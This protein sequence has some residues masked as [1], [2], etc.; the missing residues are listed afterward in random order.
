MEQSKS[1][2]QRIL[3][4][5]RAALLGGTPI[6]YIKTDSDV[7]VRRIVETSDPPLV[8]P[9][10]GGEAGVKYAHRPVSE[11]KADGLRCFDIAMNVKYNAPDGYLSMT[12]PTIWI[13][14]M[15]EE[16]RADGILQ[17]LEK[18]VA[19]HENPEHSVYEYLQSSVVIVYS[20]DVVI[21]PTLRP[22]T[23]FIDV[24]FP[25]EGEIRKIVLEESGNSATLLRNEEQMNKLCTTFHG[26]STE[27]IVSTMRRVMAL[28]S[29]EDPDKVEEL[30]LQRKMQRM[31]G[32]ALELVSAN[33]DIGGMEGFR[34]WL[35]KQVAALKNAGTY[36]RE[37]GTMPPKGVLLCGIPGCGKSEAAKFTAKTL[38]LPLLKMDVGNLMDMY[39]G[40]SEQKM[41]EALALAEAMSPCV[42]WI[43]ELEKGFSQSSGGSSDSGAAF[44]R[45]FGYMLGW[46]Q[47]NQEPCFIFATANNIGGLPK[48]FFRSGRF[49]ALYAVY[50]PTAEECVGI[51]KTSME[52]AR[53]TKASALYPG[54]KDKPLRQKVQIFAPDCFDDKI[55]LDAVNDHLV[56]D[57]KPR[58]VI[59]S[60]IQKIVSTAL[61]TLPGEK[62]ISKQQWIKALTATL[63]NQKDCA[64]YG[65]GQENI[66]S[67][68]V[69][70]CRMLRKNFVPTADYVLFRAE[71]YNAANLSEYNRLRATPTRGMS[72]EELAE[73]KKKLQAAGILRHSTQRFDN[74]YDTAVY[75]C[76]WSRIND[77]AVLVERYETD[78]LIR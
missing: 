20:S 3:E 18:Y 14:K 64:V 65:D 8:V 2:L 24:K 40:K 35:D 29:M 55:Y 15:P 75:Q 42:L 25:D 45:M 69:S 21:T 23:E 76:L 9:I 47:D 73:H 44:K 27:E 68:A 57:G 54:E 10:C 19:D 78:L 32:G 4:Q 39:V 36:K 12:Y 46:M 56:C 33:G 41:R 53:R 7:L 28:T 48:E 6:L 1:V 37:T 26:F 61:R 70:Y 30:V 49:E 62:L 31:E 11:R 52:R 22:Y 63:Q 17:K 72:E 59:G 13:C 34:R 60:D 51:F 43:D 5:S 77:M 38:G 66:D 67:I 74:A 58:I 71:D 50:L 16:R